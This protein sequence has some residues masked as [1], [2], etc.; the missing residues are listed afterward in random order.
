MEKLRHRSVCLMPSAQVP[1]ALLFAGTAYNGAVNSPERLYRMF[2][3]QFGLAAA[4]LPQSRVK[5]HYA[6]GG[7]ASQ[8][9]FAT[10][11]NNPEPSVP[12]EPERVSHS[13]FQYSFEQYVSQKLGIILGAIIV[14][15]KKIAHPLLMR[16]SA[17][18]VLDSRQI[19]FAIRMDISAI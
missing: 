9:I 16:L 19:H 7:S 11:S 3:V 2:S 1:P 5:L 12:R 17:R 18:P 15:Q 13:R 4:P 8:V 10:Q 14:C 6:S